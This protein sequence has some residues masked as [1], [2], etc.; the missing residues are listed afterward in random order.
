MGVIYKYLDENK[1]L[2]GY[3]Y[4]EICFYRAAYYKGMRY[5][6]IRFD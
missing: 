3:P 5:L 4:D 6:Y 1:K 2:I